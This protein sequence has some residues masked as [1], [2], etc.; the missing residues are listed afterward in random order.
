MK[1]HVPGGRYYEA[2][3]GDVFFDTVEHAEA[4]GYEAPVTDEAVIEETIEAEEAAAADESDAPSA[5]EDDT[6][7]AEGSA[8]DEADRR[9]RKRSGRGGGQVMGQK[10]NPYGFRLGSHH[11]LEE[12]LV[13]RAP[14]QGVPHRGLE[15]PPGDHAPHGVG[16][17]QPHRDRAHPGQGPRRRAHG[18]AG[19]RHRSS[20]RPGRRAAG[21]HHQDHRQ[22]EGAA[23]HRRD[24]EPRARRRAD[25]P[26]R[27]RPA[28]Q[29]HRLPPGHEAGRA[30]RPA[31]RRPRHPRAV[32]GPPRRRRDE[33]HRVV[34]RGPGA[35]AHAARRHR[36]RLP[37]GPHHQR[38]RR[39]EGV[40]LQGRHPPVQVDDRR[41]D[42]PRGGH[43]R[44]R[45][46]R[47]G[48]RAAPRRVVG[49]PPPGRGRGRAASS[50][51]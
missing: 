1:Y 13:Q 4:A 33:P 31:R 32:L 27:R 36:L 35:A 43:G 24:Q 18:T 44:R 28:G 5:S 29:P 37:R 17:D 49:R 23:E 42:R 45:D 41:Q 46:V 48:R 47:P 50:P 10:I 26:G 16:G 8:S 9:R 40:A 6:A 2:T 38:P 22:P 21:D 3:I 20:R 15:D 34:P 14:V 30:E 7:T 12:P 39:R 51:S 11:R 25:R 19:H